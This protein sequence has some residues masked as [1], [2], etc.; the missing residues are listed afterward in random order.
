[1]FH[2]GQLVKLR[3][4][5]ALM[6][7]EKI[8]GDQV[9]CIWQVNGETKRELFTAILLKDATVGPQPRL[10]MTGVVLG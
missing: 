3:S 4:G 6:T 1:M 8:D 9:S 5:G 10:A 7:V 2:C